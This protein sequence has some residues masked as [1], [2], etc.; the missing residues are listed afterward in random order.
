[1]QTGCALGCARCPLNSCAPA[2]SWLCAWLCAVVVPCGC[3][4]FFLHKRLA[5]SH[6]LVRSVLHKVRPEVAQRFL[7]GIRSFQVMR[8]WQTGCALGCVRCPPKQ[9]C[10]RVLVVVRIFVCCGCAL[11]LCAVL[12]HNRIA[13]PHLL[14]CSVLHKVRPEVAQRFLRGIRSF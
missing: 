12:L 1:V 11:W 8:F 5:Q 14:M 2:F 6:W 10:A 4:Q 7:C 13:Q 9:L 3:A